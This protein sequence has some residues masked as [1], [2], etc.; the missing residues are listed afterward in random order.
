[1]SIDA[2]DSFDIDEAARIINKENAR[3]EA[4]AAKQ[5]KEAQKEG[6]RIAEAIKEADPEVREIWGFGSTFEEDR[7]YRLNS[8]IDL[9][10]EG[11]DI[12]K[13][14][15]IADKSGFKVDVVDISANDRFTREVKKN[16]IRLV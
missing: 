1:M 9:A 16:G 15:R 12:L 14:W 2:A 13:A 6:R 5:R 8:D 4:F 7:P 3:Q 11:G 10:V